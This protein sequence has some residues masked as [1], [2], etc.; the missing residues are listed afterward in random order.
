MHCE[1]ARGE[2]GY[3]NRYT[4]FFFEE[5]GVLQWLSEISGEFKLKFFQSLFNAY[6]LMKIDQIEERQHIL[7]CRPGI[8]CSRQ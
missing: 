3:F 2:V 1:Q 8:C 7:R 5:N 6:F 4:L